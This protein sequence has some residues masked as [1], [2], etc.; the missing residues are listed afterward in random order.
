MRKRKQ[1]SKKDYEECYLDLEDA[2]LT[3]FNYK[4]KVLR[5]ENKW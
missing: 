3:N 2:Y 4:D 1:P 5:K